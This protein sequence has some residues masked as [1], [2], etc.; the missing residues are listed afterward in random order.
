[1][2][3]GFKIGKIFGIDI[4]IHWTLALLLFISLIP[5]SYGDYLLFLIII[6]L[7]VCV[8]L[9][10]LAHSFT[11]IKNDIPVKEITLNII[12]GA[13]IIDI[14]KVKADTELRIAL[15][16]PIASIFIG[17]IFGILSVI[18]T[19]GGT[20]AYLLQVM[21]EINILLGIFNLIPAF[22]MD[23]GRVLKSYLQKKRT[24]FNATILTAKISSVV[25]GLFL[26]FSF[27]YTIL[28]NGSIIYKEFEFFILLFIAVFLH[29]GSQA[30]KES[31]II[32]NE[33]KSLSA[34]DIMGNDFSIISS[35][36]SSSDVYKL[37]LSKRQD[38]L[39]I[40]DK[41]NFSYVDPFKARTY[42]AKTAK[43]ISS[44][45][46][47]INYKEA[48]F[49]TLLKLQTSGVGLAVVMKNN[50]PVGVITTQRIQ[51]FI[52]LHMLANKSRKRI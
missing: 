36:L 11:A 1:M 39:L 47:A 12:G 25:I 9:H 42:L 44:S 32:K 17:C 35:N 2:A 23:G 22:P 43:D 13:S 46:I 19:S 16:G 27:V 14:T 49:N 10:E 18:Y 26:F 4:S 15:V 20:V 45:A 28:I 5:L 29:S 38:I 41:D 7:F 6:L 52:Y 3:N 24:E 51:S 34:F 37:A 21:F 40:K 30:E 33:C 48:A 8:F 50:K 31:A